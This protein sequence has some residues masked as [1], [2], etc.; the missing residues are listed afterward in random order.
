MMLKPEIVHVLQREK[1]VCETALVRLQEKTNPLEKKFGWST[2]L[3]LDRFKAGQAGDEQDFF[4]WYALAEAIE[5]WQTTYDSLEELLT[6]KE[7]V[8]A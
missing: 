6:N 2:E 3:F 5:D 1:A 8:N 4:R 7:L